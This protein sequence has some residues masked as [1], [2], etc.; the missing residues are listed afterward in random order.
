MLT[1]ERRRI[2][3]ELLALTNSAICTRTRY[4]PEL[5]AGLGPGEFGLENDISV[6]RKQPQHDYERNDHQRPP[7]HVPRVVDPQLNKK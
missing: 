7:R 4:N 3:T 1:E 6:L 2:L 5:L